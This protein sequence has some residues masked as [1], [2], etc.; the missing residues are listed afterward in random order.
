MSPKQERIVWIDLARGFA[1]LSVIALHAGILPYWYFLSAFQLPLF[2]FLTGYSTN[3][4]NLD[5]T[6]LGLRWIKWGSVY[7]LVGSWCVDDD[8]S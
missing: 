3:W 4:Q 1:I 2:A 7:L 5:F 6:K 8:K